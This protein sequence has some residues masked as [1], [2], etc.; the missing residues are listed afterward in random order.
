MPGC[1]IPP[2][3]S[4]R[5]GDPEDLYFEETDYPLRHWMEGQLSGRW[6]CFIY[7]DR[8]TARVTTIFGYPTRRL[9][10]LG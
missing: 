1:S 6:R 9:S 3:D 8:D 4:P 7:I 2:T 10:K 5:D